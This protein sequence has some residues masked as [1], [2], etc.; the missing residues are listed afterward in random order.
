MN[1]PYNCLD[2]IVSKYPP[3]QINDE[4]SLSSVLYKHTKAQFSS[5]RS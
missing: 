1:S 4:H 3:A 2:Q 5:Q